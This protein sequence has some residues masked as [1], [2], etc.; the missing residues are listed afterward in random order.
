M[1]RN[2]KTYGRFRSLD[3]AVFIRDLLIENNWNLD[4]INEICEIGD[5]FWVVKVIDD[6]IH[7]LGKYEQKPSKK[8]IDEL[9]KRQI[10][11]PNNSKYGLNITKV[12]DTF[13][14]KKQLAGDDY[15]FGYY[16][17]LEDAEFVRNFLLDHHWDVASFSQTEYDENTDSYKVV[18]VIDDRAYVLGTF[19]TEDI[20]IEEVHGEF[21]NKISKHKFGLASHDY[22]NELSDRLPQ[23]E[24]RFNVKANDDVWS[25]EN[26]QNP[27]NDIIFSLMPFEQSVY[28]AVDNSTIEDIEK[29]LIRFK[30]KNFT[31]KIRKNLDDLIDKGLITKNQNHYMKKE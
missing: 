7:I 9:T 2:S 28:D 19:K 18:E 16:D 1:I 14:I 6:R 29:S 3:D 21:L 13:V 17:N 30:S 22:L 26:A 27:L 23:L 11:N 15:I 10:R 4:L 12:F 31:Q 20:A 25:F 8:T 24:K 5:D